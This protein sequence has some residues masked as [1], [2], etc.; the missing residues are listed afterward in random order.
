MTRRN[1]PEGVSR[2]SPPSSTDVD[3]TA[4]LR[5]RALALILT[6]VACGKWEVSAETLN[7]LA[8]LGWAVVW[9]LEADDLEMAA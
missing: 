2:V 7:A 1:A 8:D 6:A 4:V 3:N 5:A 9:D